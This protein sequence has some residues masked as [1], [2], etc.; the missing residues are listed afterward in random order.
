MVEFLPGYLCWENYNMNRVKKRLAAL[1]GLP[2]SGQVSEKPSWM[3]D[4]C[5][6]VKMMIIFPPPSISLCVWQQKKEDEGLV[7][8]GKGVNAIS[9][10]TVPLYDNCIWKTQAATYLPPAR[11]SGSKDVLDCLRSAQPR[12]SHSKCQKPRGKYACQWGLNGVAGA[13]EAWGHNRQT[14][15]QTSQGME[16]LCQ[17]FLGEPRRS[18]IPLTAEMRNISSGVLWGE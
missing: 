15:N 7:G 2:Q 3:W 11:H 16:L 10:A 1:A 18:N 14:H 17:P 13:P 6:V 9:R 8:E 5:P 4:R 12:V